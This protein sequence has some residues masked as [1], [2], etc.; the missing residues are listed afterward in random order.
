MHLKDFDYTLPEELIAKFPSDNRTESRL[1]CLDSIS[2]ELQHK[3]FYDIYSLLEDGDLLI[4]NDTKVIPARL[5]GT[6]DTGGKIEVLIEQILEDNTA[7][8]QIRAS[9]APK[10]GAK[11][12]VTTDNIVI[13]VQKRQENLFLIKFP[14]D[15]LTILNRKGHIPLPPYMQRQ[16]VAA[17]DSRYQTVYASKEGAV[18][19]PTAGLHFDNQLLQKLTDKGVNHGFVTLHVGAG[20]YQPVRTDTIE[21]HIMHS[22]YIEVSPELCDLI[23][24]T[25]QRGKRVIAVGTTVVR[26]L[27]SASASGAIQPF[28]GRS[29]LFIYPGYTFNTVDALITNFHFPQSTLL[30][31]VSAFAGKENILHS[32]QEAIANKYRFFSYGDAMFIKNRKNS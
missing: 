7:L 18:A 29:S 22:E 11:L 6:K 27:E 19:A 21:E 16:A 30:M 13:T 4:M 28:Q 17:D 2:G 24:K 25:K 1:L 26:S 23:N 20:T 32:Y 15:I 3:K 12:A 10:P 5:Y 31:L 9:K 8:A 14:S